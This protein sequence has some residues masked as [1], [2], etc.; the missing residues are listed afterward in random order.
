MDGIFGVG[1]AEMLI[2]GL[3]LFVIGGPENTAKWAR[4][5]GKMVYKGRKMWADLMA[6][7]EKELGPEGKELVD[8]T[9]ELGKG[10]REI[11]QMSPTKRVLGE[12]MRMVES[13][14]DIEGAGEG[15]SQSGKS[16][17]APAGTS[18]P[19]GG[20]SGNGQNDEKKYQAWLP[21]EGE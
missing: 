11:R 5:L 4:E 8:V 2:I 10:A 19:A 17:G 18:E 14:V 21:P 7:M 20:T 1:L 12:T 13:A 15:E 9:R 6:Q 16:K 3:A